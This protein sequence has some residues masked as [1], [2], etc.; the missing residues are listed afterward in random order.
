MVKAVFA[1]NAILQTISGKQEGAPVLVTGS[2]QQFLRAVGAPHTDVWD[3]R[4]T[5]ERIMVDGALASV[6]TPYRFYLNE[7]F[8]HCGVNSFQL[9]KSAS[10]WK[11]IYL[12]DTR[13]SSGLLPSRK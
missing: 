6:W 12:V 7:K 9:M 11:I 5:F 1:D 13:Y 10:G 3:E 8:S 2:L 4:I